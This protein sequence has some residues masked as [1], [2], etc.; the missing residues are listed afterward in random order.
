MVVSII[1]RNAA[2]NADGFGV[3]WYSPPGVDTSPYALSH[4]PILF[5]SV[6][7]AEHN[8]NLGRLASRMESGVI[9][10]HA[11]AASP[12]S[13]IHEFN[14]HPFQ[15]G[16]YA[17]M[18]NGGVANFRVLKRPIQNLLSPS[19][20]ALVKG[21]TDSE[22]CG[23]LFIDQLPN[24]DPY[25]PQ[26]AEVLTAAL[27]RVLVLI[28]DLA[29]QYGNP[30]LPATVVS[31]LN[32]AVTD[33]HTSVCSRFRDSSVEDPPSLYYAQYTH[34]GREEGETEFYY[35]SKRPILGT[36]VG[37]EP[38]TYNRVV[39]NVP[40]ANALAPW[41]PVPKNHL[42]TI[43][44]D[45]SYT[46]TPVFDS[47]Y[48]ARRVIAKWKALVKRPKAH[49]P[50]DPLSATPVALSVD[51]VPPTPDMTA[52]ISSVAEIAAAS[53]SSS[54]QGVPSLQDLLALASPDQLRF[55]LTS[56]T[57]SVSSSSS[58]ASSSA[59]RPNFNQPKEQMI[60]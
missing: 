47:D 10:G 37:S 15:F 55:L 17:F 46:L 30:Y 26:P 41:T 5:T 27:R 52:V 44:E 56:M 43:K 35:D 20:Y 39:A 29:Q 45:Y 36:L 28:H 23:A 59:P 25:A 34:Y 6:G 11:R 3:A 16:R 24:R 9:F 50:V 32:F 57:P 40:E 60:D 8:V 4:E 58:N 48:V 38:L 42:I 2:V 54:A 14:C 12:G 18:H 19:S 13:P 31:S 1:R 49:E 33:G 51:S 7:P 21:T 22:L 53:S